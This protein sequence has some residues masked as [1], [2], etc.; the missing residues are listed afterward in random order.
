M[1]FH[2]RLGPYRKEL[3]DEIAYRHDEWYEAWSHEATLLPVA[4]EPH[5]RWMR[6][7]ARDG[8]TWKPLA[9]VAERE[10]GYV[11]S[12]LDEVRERGRVAGGELSDPRPVDTGSGGWW[13]RSLGVLALDWLFR[14]GDLGVRRRGNF[15]KVFSPLEDIVP[16]DV[17]SSPT[18]SAGEAHRD[19]TLQSVQALGVGTV[20]D[21]AD[22]FRLK[23]KEVQPRLEELIEMGAVVPASVRGW[24]KPAYADAHASIPRAIRGATMLSPFDPVVWNRDRALRLFDFHYRIE[25]YTPAEKRQYG[26]Y[27]LPVLVDGHLVARLDVKTDREASVLRIKAAHAEPGWADAATA[28]RVGQAVRDLARLVEV[29]DVD[30]EDRGDLARLLRSS[31]R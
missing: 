13:H 25:I 19:L 16:A 17:L 3:L 6:D 24:D 5:F 11:Q 4:T 15:E 30:V 7:R 2:S 10:P 31:L 23:T 12:V 26:Y 8:R 21:I 9:E 29:S 27:V 22:Y 28:E 1:P 14:V 20:S 18:P